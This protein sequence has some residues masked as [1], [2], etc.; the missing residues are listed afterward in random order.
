M[1][2]RFSHQGSMQD[3]HG[4]TWVNNHYLSLRPSPGNGHRIN[5]ADIAG[6]SFIGICVEK[7]LVSGTHD[8][9]DDDTFKRY[10]VNV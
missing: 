2:V 7:R 10:T 4:S 3:T 8:D 9:D 6:R 5:W 1:K